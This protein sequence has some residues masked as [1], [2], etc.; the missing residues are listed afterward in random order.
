MSCKSGQKLCLLGVDTGG[1]FTDFVYVDGDD[2]RLHK[3][4][5]TPAAPER[6]IL[7][8]I[9]EMQLD[10]QQLRII[11]GST[12]A[13]NAVLQNRG[14]RTA[15]VTNKGLKD[16]LTIGRQARAELY[17]LQ[18][19][20][21]PP[22]V[23]AELCLEIDVRRDQQGVIIQPLKSADI[24]RLRETLLQRQ[25]EAVAINLL[26]SFVSSDDE[27]QIAAA[28]ENDFF[29]SCSHR[30]L[31]EYRE[32]E[33]G[34]ATWLNASVGPLVQ[35]YL[36]RLSAAVKPAR[37]SVM[38]SSGQTCD[39][40]QAGTEAVHLLLSGPAGGLAAAK[41]IGETIGR[42]QLLTFDMGGTSTD[43]AM[44]NG[45]INIMGR[46]RIGRYPV[47]VPMV[48][49][50]TIGA[51]GGSIAHVD[52]G[53][54]L[55]V[56]PESA[57][58]VPGPACYGQ[59]GQ[60]ATVTDANLVLGRIPPQARLGGS[61]QLDVA[62][63]DTA[64]DSLAADIGVDSAAAAAEGVIRV[65]NE[66]MVQALRMISVQRG[67]DPK[68]FSLFAFGGAGGLHI[69]A[70][71]EA[72]NMHQAVVPDRAGVLSALGMI[73][74]S[75]G[76][77]LKQTLAVMLAGI[78]GQELQQQRQALIDT[79]IERLQQEDVNIDSIDITTSVDL[80]YHGQ[81]STLNLP[82]T[83][84][85]TMQQQFHELHQQRFGHRLQ[86]PIELVNLCVS[87]NAA[88]TSLNLPKMGK[89]ETGSETEHVTA[90]GFDQA[91]PVRPRYSLAGEPPQPGPLIVTDPVATTFVAKN[92]YASLDEYA[93]L[94][95][96]LSDATP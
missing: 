87:L 78:T 66:N 34:I 35:G 28:L 60:A 83:D 18:P 77:Y 85:E 26:F 64:L 33:R 57:A 39:T 95:L 54:K 81:S 96:T 17:N 63:A 69:C 25:V 82:L 20:P 92:W 21:L 48:E 80:C 51:G 50:E 90:Y 91:I 27:Q 94:I 45:G 36:Q 73:V 46:G 61:L 41:F 14:V 62:A 30:V 31:P 88:P 71:A 70:L 68:D 6:A 13:T 52:A 29:V 10:L 37:V 65:V 53:G 56:G 24:S 32:Y 40:G 15:Y 49:M 67:I 72:L 23:P 75:P 74:T 43:V 22:P 16:V 84:T 8:G 55:H 19:Q 12:V 58:S 5:S 38:R 47:G 3:V 11:H 93:N 1:T 44:I 76:R 4:L 86:S 89:P 79:G 9:A 42:R 59:C 2:I 7:Q